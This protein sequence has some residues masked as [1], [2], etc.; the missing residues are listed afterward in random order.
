ME[1][2]PSG[3]LCHISADRLNRSFSD[4]NHLSRLFAQPDQVFLVV[5]G[6]RIGSFLLE[7]EHNCTFTDSILAPM[8]R[9]QI[10]VP[11]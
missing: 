6:F 8:E 10:K 3:T 9:Y 4:V 5:V 1:K 11:W 7:I 2:L